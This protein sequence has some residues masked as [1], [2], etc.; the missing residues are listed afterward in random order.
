MRIGKW[1]RL[2]LA[3]APLLAGCGNFWQAP[4]G[5]SA[6]E[7]VYPYQQRQHRRSSQ[8]QRH[9]DDYGDAGEFVYRDRY[10]GLL[11][12]QLAFGLY[13]FADMQPVIHF[14]QLLRLRRHRPRR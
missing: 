8:R 13:Q 7:V 2:M 10:A 11:D 1:G 14:T 4:G 12:Y 6:E 3:V 9:I 5:S